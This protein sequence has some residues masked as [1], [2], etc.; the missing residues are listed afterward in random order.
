VMVKQCIPYQATRCVP[1]CVPCTE[2]VTCT[3]MVCKTICKQVPVETCAPACGGCNV[4]NSCGNPC[5]T[6]TGSCG[7][8]SSCGTDACGDAP[9]AEAPAKKKHCLHKLFG[10]K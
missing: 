5:A 2:K 3:R 8:G 4:A 1:T 7:C 10:G 9:A 6:T